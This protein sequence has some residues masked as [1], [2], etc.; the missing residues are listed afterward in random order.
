MRGGGGVAELGL[1]DGVFDEARRGGF[2]DG[3]AFY[4]CSAAEMG[5]RNAKRQGRTRLGVLCGGYFVKVF[6]DAGLRRGV[7]SG[8]GLEFKNRLIQTHQL[9]DDGVRL[10]VDAL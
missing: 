4:V 5:K 1:R 9:S 6:A 10:R 2:V 8:P 7:G 3:A